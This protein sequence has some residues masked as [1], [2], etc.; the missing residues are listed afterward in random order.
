MN[1]TSIA[2][3]AEHYDGG[4]PALIVTRE[5]KRNGKPI[6]L[7]A[8]I[9]SDG[10]RSCW[11]SN[12]KE[13]SSFPKTVAAQQFW[14]DVDTARDAAVRLLTAHWPSQ[15]YRDA[16]EEIRDHFSTKLEVASR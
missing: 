15:Q 8:C 14:V 5:S 6:L 4:K 2:I 10:H 9:T 12:R 3:I 16:I 11:S 13:I 1:Q 7:G